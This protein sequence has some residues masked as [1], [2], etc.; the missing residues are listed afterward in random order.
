[1]KKRDYSLP[2]KIKALK[3]YDKTTLAKISIHNP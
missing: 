1:M 2:A 3:G